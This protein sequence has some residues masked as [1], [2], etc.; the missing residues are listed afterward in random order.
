MAIDPYSLCPGGTG[1]KLKFCCSDLLHE[2]GKIDHMLAAEQRQACVDYITQLEAKFPDRACLLTTKALVLHSLEQDDEALRTADRVLEAQPANP[3]ALAVRALVLADVQDPAQALKPLHQALLA[4]GHQVPQRVFDAVGAVAEGLLAHG[5]IVSSLAHL[6]WQSSVKPDYEPALML[7]YRVQSSNAIPLVLKD[8]R[9]SFDSAPPGLS[10]QAEFD[11]ALTEARDGLWLKAAEQFSA[12]T[13]RAAGCASLWRNL[14]LLRAYLAQEAGAAEALRRY[15]SLDVRL[16]DAVEAEV[17]AQA[18]DPKTAE[19]TVE[20]VRVVYEYSDIDLV[21]SRLST[22]NRAMREASD[23]WHSEESDE[24]PPR[25]MFSILDRAMPSEAE[26]SVETM[27]EAIAVGLLFGRQTDRPPRLELLCERPNAE[28]A[29][30]Q[31]NQ[32]LG[33]AVGPPVSEET[34]GRVPI[35]Q[36]SIRGTWRVPPGTPIARLKALTDERRRKY[37]LDEWPREP[38]PALNGRSLEQAASDRSSQVAVLALIALWELH[39]GDRLDFNELRGRLGLPLAEPIDLQ[40]PD[41]AWQTVEA[42][43][44]ILLHRLDAKKLSDEQLSDTLHRAVLFR[45]RIA[46]FRLAAEVE[47]RPSARAIDRAQA[48]GILASFA[49]DLDAAL[50]HLAQARAAAKE[51]N[52]SCAGFDLE[53]LAVRLSHGRPEGFM[54]LI[55]HINNAHRQEPGVAERLFQFL[56]QAGLIDEQGRPREAPAP[57]PTELL[58]PGGGEAA[59]GKIWTPESEAGEGK[60]SSLWVPGS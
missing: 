46:T 40:S 48:H 3:V 57:Q 29:K 58:V 34:A 2:L 31:V 41:A 60:K 50:G 15:A 39:Y 18:L 19:A 37:L 23:G 1:K 12:L 32:V 11:A 38:N 51:A 10:C 21:S 27:P 7:I 54:E 56:Y 6:V 17:L 16:D 44:L 25:A 22:S 43:P 36:G 13:F 52:A 55:R 35:P 9:F 33:D 26:L 49:E 47:S 42:V 53:E 20:Q 59:A 24:P 28:R 4:C 14:G 45:A 30:E 5:Y 8:I